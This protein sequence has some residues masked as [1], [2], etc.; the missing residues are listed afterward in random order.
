MNGSN[1]ANNLVKVTG[2]EH[3]ILHLLLM[4][5]C[6]KSGNKKIYAKSVY[7]VMCFTMNYYHE[8]RYI[9][10]SRVVES[11]KLKISEFRRGKNPPN[12]GKNHTLLTRKKMSDKHWLKNGGLHPMLGKSHDEESIEKMRINS[13]KQWWDAYSPEGEYFHKVSLNEMI[14]K[15]NLNGDCIRKFKGKII[16]EVPQNQKK[17]AK[18]P[19]LNTTGW[20][21]I[22]L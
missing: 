21:F 3:Y 10:P 7:S 20:L 13:T 14:R 15:Y 2:R 4:K 5:V 6:E 17:Q 8:D 9:V 16:P 12:K 1:T 11:I 19:R 18:Y 22:P